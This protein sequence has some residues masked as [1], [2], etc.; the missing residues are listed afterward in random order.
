M[1]KAQGVM[2][3]YK[4]QAPNGREIIVFDNPVQF[5]NVVLGDQFSDI[6][7]FELVSDANGETEF[8]AVYD[9]DIYEGIK[10]FEVCFK[11][12]TIISSPL[13]HLTKEFLKK[14]NGTK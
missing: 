11:N 7:Y 5:D 2:G 10:S 14:V 9:Y 13:R 4:E 3:W 1:N 12:K 6:A 8:Q